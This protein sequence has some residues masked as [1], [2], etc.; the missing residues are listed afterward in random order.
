MHDLNHTQPPEPPEAAENGA[1][2]TF[3]T[4]LAGGIV[5][6]IINIV[7]ILANAS[8]FRQIS[9]SAGTNVPASGDVAGLVG[10][11][12]CMVIIIGALISFFAGFFVGKRTIQRRLGFY[13]GALVGL[14]FFLSNS[15]MNLLP[16]SPTHVPNSGPTSSAG[17]TIGVMFLILVAAIYSVIAGLLGLLGARIATGKHP[18]YQRQAR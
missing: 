14:L 11:L 2:Y 6:A 13:A 18:Y 4:G 1:L 16:I 10:G 17:I 15:V 12:Q 9:Q 3:I 7:I 8:A 5:L